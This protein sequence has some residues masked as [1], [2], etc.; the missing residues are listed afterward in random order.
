M[1]GVLQFIKA[2]IL[3]IGFYFIF[4]IIIDL[5]FDFC[6]EKIKNTT[7]DNKM[8]QFIFEKHSFLMPLIIFIVCWIPYLIIYFPG[9]LVPDSSNQIIQFFG[10]DISATSSTNSVNLIDPNVK[11][12][13]HQ[14]V[15]HT[16]IL[17]NCMNIGKMIG[18]DNIG[19][20]IYTILQTALLASSLAYIINYMKKLK[21]NKWIRIFS[22]IVF[23]V[24]PIFPFYAIEITKDVPYVCIGIFYI[25]ELYKLI[26][27]SKEKI[28][29]KSVLPIIALSLL[30]CLFRNNGIYT[31]LLS[32]PFI[33]IIAK[34]N[35]KKV[36]AATLSV[37]IIYEAFVKAVLPGVFK[38]P[39]TGVREMLSVPFQQTARYVTEH[40]NEITNEDKEIIDK[41]L[42]YNTLSKRYVP[43]N[44]D[45]VKNKYN[46]DATQE[47]LKKYFGVWFKHLFKHPDVYIQSF[48]NNYYGYVYLG[49]DINSY[50]VSANAIKNDKR[51]AKTGKFNY[52]YIKG[53]EKARKEAVDFL[54][55][56][57]DMP[58][59]SCFSNIALNNY[60][61]L[62]MAVY[63]LYKKKYRYIIFLLPSFANILICFVSPVNAYFRYAM[64]NIFAMPLIISIFLSIVNGK[65]KD[66]EENSN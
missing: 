30:L 42:E 48:L 24:L 44:A 23:S 62:G 55:T 32:L 66:G 58:I 16:F 63:L 57:K 22:L 59:I 35:R 43:T 8:F 65:V 14:P 39:N 56:T 49:S 64:P 52:S 10:M 33:T 1:D 54:D 5:I 34:P 21:T 51:L 7:S 15:L 60:I 20:F 29:I 3:G 41:V 11:I 46:K 27:N 38:I 45:T 28:P 2:V 13:N 26:K 18:N 53:F 37:F 50:I 31:V 9:M 47:D 25:G 17:G 4:K 12:T 36:L 40:E 6:I 61:I 19:I